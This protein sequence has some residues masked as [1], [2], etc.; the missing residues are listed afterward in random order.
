[1]NQPEHWECELYS[2]VKNALEE[3]GKTDSSYYVLVGELIQ[4]CER[5]SGHGRGLSK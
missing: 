2:K 4:R 3:G 5:G 1:M